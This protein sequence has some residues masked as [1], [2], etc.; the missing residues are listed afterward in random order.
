TVSPASPIAGKSLAEAGI[1]AGAIVAA[2][3]RG[4][5]VVVPRG[6]DRIEVGD[7]VVVFTLPEAAQAVSEYFPA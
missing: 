1:P 5:E 6:H 4:T 2:I 3:V 7:S